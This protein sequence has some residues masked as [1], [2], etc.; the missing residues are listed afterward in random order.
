MTMGNEKAHILFVE[1][2]EIQARLVQKEFEAYAYKYRLTMASSLKEAREAITKAL[3]DLVITD[4][5]LPDGLGTELLTPKHEDPPYPVVVMTAIGGEK[6]AVD[7]MKAGA[8]D[9]VV[10]SGETPGATPH[11]AE[12]ALREWDLMTQ[13][14]MM[15][16]ALR[17]SEAKYRELVQ[18]VNSFILR[19][20]PRG[21]LTF[22]NEYAQLFFGYA[23]DQLIGKNLIGT[24]MPETDSHGRDHV[25]LLQ[26]ITQNPERY[27]TNESENVKNNGTRVWVAW[28]HKAIRDDKGVLIEMLC[29]GNDITGRKKTHDERLQRE[30]LQGVLEM[31]GA[32]CH[33]MNQPVQVIATYSE[34]L[35]K[36]LPDTDPNYTYLNMINEEVFRM[37]K[38]S[39]KL[40]GITKY[41]T[42][43]YIEGSKII[44]LDRASRDGEAHGLNT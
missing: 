38:I 7:V 11:I 24:I 5:L 42:R 28:T 30:K 8:L 41:E 25:A 17:R 33:E 37:K 40:Q 34:L 13:R 19:I 1:D 15:E 18:S 21:N 3:P 35:V 12:R 43:D 27:A 23:E 6:S 36:D 14:K 32:V 29:V 16:E 20:D 10:K 31:A 9:Y 22:L 4:L 39:E 2:E 26:D 44:D